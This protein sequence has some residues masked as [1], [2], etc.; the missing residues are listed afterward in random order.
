VVGFP[1]REKDFSHL[2]KIHTGSGT[3]PAS[4]TVRTGPFYQGHEVGYLPL[5]SSKVNEDWS[6]TSPS[7]Y[8]P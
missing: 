5:S 2:V 7:P 1:A 8:R 4:F 3:C 6:H